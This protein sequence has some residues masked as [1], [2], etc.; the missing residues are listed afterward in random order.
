MTSKASL[1][2]FVRFLTQNNLVHKSGQTWV[3]H[4]QPWN[5]I[6]AKVFLQP[7]QKPHEVENSKDVVLHEDSQRRQVVDSVIN[8]M[9]QKLRPQIRSLGKD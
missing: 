5:G 3:S 4:R 6:A 2:I 9:V 7:F 8:R 1:S